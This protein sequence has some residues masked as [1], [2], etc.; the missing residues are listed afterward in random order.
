VSTYFAFSDESGEYKQNR[1]EKF[2]K[3]SPYYIRATLLIL[4][5]DWKELNT[6]FRN[7][8]E[9]FNLPLEKEIKW[10]YIWPLKQ[11]LEYGQS[12]PEKKP[13]YFLK[14]KDYNEIIK[15]IDS[16]LKFLSELN[17]VKIIITVTSNKHCKTA[18]RNDIYKW[19]IQDQMER[20][21]MELQKQEDNLCVFFIDSITEKNNKLLRDSY[22]DLYQN[23]DFIERYSHIIDSLNIEYSHHSSGIQFVDYIVGSFRGFL[24]GYENSKEIYKNRIR[25]YLRTGNN[26]EILGYG[27]KEVPTNKE[28]VRTYIKEI[29]EK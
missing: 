8:K 17:Y 15:F 9:K 12:I 1:S 26:N 20:I 3:S 19:H 5:S 11:Y 22:F 2:I 27:I 6:K 16:S 7:N 13:F 23:G 29:L 28:E 4:A 14:D 10:S 18:S 24:R 21:E 25:P